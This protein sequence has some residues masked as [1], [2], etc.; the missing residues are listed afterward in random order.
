MLEKLRASGEVMAIGATHYS[1]SAFDEMREVMKTG[2]VTSIQTAYNP[3]ERDVEQ[4]VLPLAADLG[5]GVIVMRPFGEGSLVRSAPPA[6]ELQP[7]A[8]FGVTTWPQA[9][10]KWSL[11]DPRC[12][13]AIPATSN[14]AHVRDNARERA[15][16]RGLGPMLFAV[17]RLARRSMIQISPVRAAVAQVFRPAVCERD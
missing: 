2:R 10:L 6:S 1:P 9:L 14:P 3:F 16:H 7:L 11:S 15:P 5:L 8:M 4:R 12:H 13:I 17:A